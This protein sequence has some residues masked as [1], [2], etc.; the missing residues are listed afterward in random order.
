MFSSI[1]LLPYRLAFSLRLSTDGSLRSTKRKS[2]GSLISQRRWFSATKSFLDSRKRRA[3]PS[4]FTSTS[5]RV[6]LSFWAIFLTS[7]SCN[8]VC[9]ASFAEMVDLP[10]PGEPVIMI[11]ISE[12][13]GKK[14]EILSRLLQGSFALLGEAV[15]FPPGPKLGGDHPFG[16]ELVEH[17]VDHYPVWLEE[18]FFLDLQIESVGVELPPTLHK[19]EHVQ[20]E[21]AVGEEVLEPLDRSGRTFHPA[22]PNP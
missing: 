13:I 22:T 16:L 10:T 12:P 18:E 11:L 9:A 6:P 5:E 19:R 17:H 21:V 7:I 14:L 15:I 20:P 1:L 3:F 2:L 4:F 8:D